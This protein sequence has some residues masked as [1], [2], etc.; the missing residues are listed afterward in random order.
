[1]LLEMES[2]LN[3]HKPCSNTIFRASLGIG[4]NYFHAI[5]IGCEGVKNSLFNF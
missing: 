5:S 4:N 3:A 1:M 2:L